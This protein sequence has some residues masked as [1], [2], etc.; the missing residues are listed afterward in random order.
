M[1]FHQE[2]PYKINVKTSEWKEL[3]NNGSIRII[4]TIF[5]IKK[6]HK[7]ILLQKKGKVIKKIS[8]LARR[9][10]EKLLSYKVHL[11]INVK[12]TP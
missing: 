12:I 6:S 3:K 10:L 2:I 9:E 7:A 1:G 4:Q 8:L 5:V 11:F